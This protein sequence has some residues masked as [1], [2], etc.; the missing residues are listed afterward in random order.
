MVYLKFKYNCFVF[1]FVFHNLLTQPANSHVS[2]MNSSAQLQS[3]LH[4][5]EA[6]A[7]ILIATLGKTVN[8][9]LLPKLLLNS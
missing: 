2:G 8:Q 9:N 7:D 1:V 6:I 4:L 5:T 3:N